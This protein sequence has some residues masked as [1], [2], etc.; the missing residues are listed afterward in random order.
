[1]LSIIENPIANKGDDFEIH[2]RIT[3]ELGK[4]GFATVYCCKDIRT[5][6]N[7]AVK[8]ISK[9]NFLLNYYLLFYVYFYR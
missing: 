9:T 7:H 1:M 5:G 8:V 3:N 2:Y 6:R 4:G